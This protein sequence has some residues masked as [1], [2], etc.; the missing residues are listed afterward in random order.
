MSNTSE[1]RDAAYVFA[2]NVARTEFQD[3][4]PKTVEAAKKSILDTLGVMLGATGTTPSLNGIIDLVKET[5]GRPE[6]TI[7]GFGGKAPAMMAAFAN[8]AMAHCLDYDDFE[9]VSTYHPSSAV[10]PAAFAIAEKNRPVGG[11]E[12]ITAI[13]L[14][15]DLGIRLALAIPSQ[16]KP[17]WHRT[18]VLS[19][20][21]AAA[22]VAKILKLDEERIVDALG[23]AF[24][25]SAGSL[26]LRWG[27]GSDL[28]GMYSAFPAKAG[29]LSALLAEKGVAGIKN[30]FEG[31]AG[32]F[33]LYFEGKYDP[34]V[35]LCDLG[36]KFTGTDTAL[37]PWPACAGTYTSIDAILSLMN[38]NKIQ[39]EDIDRIIVYFGD[40]TQGL[41]EP[42][43]ARQKPV[44]APDAK[45]SLPYSVAV[46]ALRGNLVIDDFGPLALSDPKILEMA[47]KVEPK[48]DPRLNITKGLP[49]GV[50][51]IRTKQG[52]T[53][54]REVE[55]PY[56]H[57]ENPLTWEGIKMKF[58]DCFKHAIKPLPEQNAMSV[59]ELIENLE[60]VH[61][62][63]V[64]IQLLAKE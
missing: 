62:V 56:G 39:P 10:V 58:R 34:K 27:V 61:D 49:P 54:Q 53:Y 43:L 7:I 29:V 12:F 52:R 38:E 23:I 42:L 16:R 18:V 31:K 13:A 8:G 44:S 19:T 40:Y 45:Y 26:E 24:C 2:S 20:F 21:A 9:Y 22:T 28:G 41:C 25:Q 59:I 50:V 63:A 30:C 1:R 15:Q 4:S 48:F 46:A 32:L 17:P 37:K 64:I 3:L 55:Q 47:Q 14:G 11:K 6:S 33:N 57:P 5:S 35:L 36:D 51:K 60:Q